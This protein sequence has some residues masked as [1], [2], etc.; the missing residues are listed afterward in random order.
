[1]EAEL[2]ERNALVKTADFGFG[3]GKIVKILWCLAV[4][5]PLEKILFLIYK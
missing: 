4:S 3:T 1:L 5:D 2:A